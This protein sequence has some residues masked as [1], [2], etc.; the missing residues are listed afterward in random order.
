MLEVSVIEF[1][2][3]RKVG[4]IRLSRVVWA[5]KSRWRTHH[6]SPVTGVLDLRGEGSW[7]LVG[8]AFL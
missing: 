5:F 4:H 1:S 8:D 6:P 2:I 7:F 3:V